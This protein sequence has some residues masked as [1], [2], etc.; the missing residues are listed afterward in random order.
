MKKIWIIL[1]LIISLALFFKDTLIKKQLPIPS[2][3]IV[4]LYYPFIDYFSPIYPRGYPLKNF[5]ITD[6]IRQTY[7]WRNLAIELEKK[8]TLP[9]WNPYSLS[10]TP[11]LANFQSSVFYPLN[12]IFFIS[13][14]SFAW[15]FLVILAPLLGGLFMILYL[16]NKRINMWGCLVGGLSFA[17]S[18][19]FV[20]WLE[21]NVLTHVLL[22]LPLLFL[23][24]DTISSNTKKRFL[25][26]VL[27]IF[28]LSSSLFAGHLQT[29]FYVFLA[30]VGYAC[31]K[32]KE[33][34]DKKKFLLS[35]F[36]S[37]IISLFIMLPQLIPGFR[38]ILESARDVDPIS[39]Q[40]E[41]QF[42]PWKHLTQFIAPDFF[43]NPAKGNYWGEWNY[44][45][46]I[47]YIGLFPLI[48][49]IFAMLFRKDNE[50]KF[51]T[52]LFILSLLFALP[53]FV[54]KVPFWLH[55]PFLSTSQSTRLLSLSC[56]SLS[57]LAA[58]GIDYYE[59]EKRKL[60]IAIGIILFIF[61]MLWGFIFLR[62]QFVPISLEQLYV[63][64]RN[65][66]FPSVLVFIAEVIAIVGI[67]I[68]QKKYMH[69]FYTLV[70]LVTLF[71][72]IWFATRFT[73][74]SPQEFLY[75][76]TKLTSFLQKNLNN[77]RYMSVDWR[78]LPPNFSIMY[79]LQSID[80]YDPL[81]LRRYGEFIVA[82]EREKPDIST[83]FGFYK[84]ITPYNYKSHLI[85]L[86]GV[87]YVL[88]LYEI[89]SPKLIK[90][91]EEGL[92][93]VY[94]NKN[95]LPRT[96]FV[97]NVE[98]LP[99]KQ[100]NLEKL[101]DPKFPLK[102]HATVEEEISSRV[103][104]V[105]KSS[106]VSYAPNEVIIKTENSGDGFLVLSDMYYPTW[107]V[108]VDGEEVKLYRADYAMRGVLVPKGIHVIRFYDTLF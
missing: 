37:L 96:F 57:I 90:V 16:A 104:T 21:W 51:F 43:G 78:I 49:A 99:N 23:C 6:P 1:L 63:A 103:F 105:G 9:L 4:G 42:L 50:T 61:I 100:Q 83:P 5:L 33:T 17:L 73:T 87:K 80:G 88:S 86:L 30:I 22:W 48:F 54:A 102:N 24:I 13:P 107:H 89:D 20:S 66:Y 72:L 56:F 28:S 106:I 92:T 85:D 31:F 58:F 26:I 70:F 82:S 19:F 46:F 41:S 93:K 38:F 18:G 71:D 52:G 53:T 14:F 44:G 7:P 25:W 40:T 81:F 47:A 29:F 69:I 59:K 27:F 91:Y 68:K 55:I 101:F 35:I 11:L 65:L 12:I 94:E 62:Q 108:Q 76:Q 98:I 77:E 15:S 95:M 39:V 60:F 45:E 34:Y 97:N 36:I 67:I 10:G 64:R 8:T 84:R 3:T 32:L 2:D 79:K 75:P 74:F